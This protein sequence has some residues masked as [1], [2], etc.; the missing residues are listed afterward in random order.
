MHIGAQFS[1]THLV[2][3]NAL[4]C[5]HPVFSLGV[6]HEVKSL[7]YKDLYIKITT[8]AYIIAT[9]AKGL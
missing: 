8:K 6:Y 1:N 2:P 7:K 9:R 4:K 3:Y 5:F